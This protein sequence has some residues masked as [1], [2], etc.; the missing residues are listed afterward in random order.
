MGV[1]KILVSG[2]FDP[3]HR[4]HIAYLKAAKELGGDLIVLIHRDECCVKKKGYC[5]MPLEDRVAVIGAIRYVDQV[6]ACEPGCDLTSCSALE[7]IKPDI[8]A[9]GGD[10]SPENMPASEVELCKKLG[11]EIVY[12]VGGGKIQSSSWL[13]ENYKKALKYAKS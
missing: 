5:F 12:G 10:R 8:F 4:G 6:I 2:F 1:K 13:I 11:I 7:K 3:P 9:K